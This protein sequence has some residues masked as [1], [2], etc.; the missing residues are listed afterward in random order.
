[1][2]IYTDLASLKIIASVHQNQSLEHV[3]EDMVH[4][5]QHQVAYFDWVGI[6][7]MEGDTLKLK[8]ASCL[9][10]ELSWECNSELRIPIKS[11]RME[12]GKLVVRSR[13]PICFDVTDV[14]TLKTLAKE[15]STKLQVN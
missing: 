4:K 12:I 1:M 10:N 8:A 5:L 9:E 15:I 6:Y 2:S 11:R 14:S 7:L 13:Q 3:F